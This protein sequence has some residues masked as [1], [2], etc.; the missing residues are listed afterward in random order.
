MGVIQESPSLYPRNGVGCGVIRESPSLC[1][2]VSECLC[3]HSSSVCDRACC[4]TDKTE[5]E[6]ENEKALHKP[7]P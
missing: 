5:R 1:P 3:A 6:R 4:K 7:T 2:F